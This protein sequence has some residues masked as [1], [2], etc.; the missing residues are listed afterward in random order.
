MELT[1]SDMNGGLSLKVHLTIVDLG[2][3]QQPLDLETPLE[4]GR[5]EVTVELASKLQKYD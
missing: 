2:Y 5:M 1:S 4:Q 3:Q